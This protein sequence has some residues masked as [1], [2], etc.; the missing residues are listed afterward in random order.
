MSVGLNLS[1]DWDLNLSRV[2]SDRRQAPGR[3]GGAKTLGLRNT[4]GE[5]EPER[6][7]RKYRI[8]SAF[9]IV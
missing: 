9:E 2:N 5:F 1:S 6:A 7:A 4:E 8:A 3:T